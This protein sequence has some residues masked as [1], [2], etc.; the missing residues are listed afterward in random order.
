MGAGLTI[1]H[2]ISTKI[3]SVQKGGSEN[4]AHFERGWYLGGVVLER[5]DLTPLETMVLIDI[6]Y[7]SGNSRYTLQNIF[8]QRTRL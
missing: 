4:L 7:K 2:T 1:H 6:R 3:D 8:K 5:G